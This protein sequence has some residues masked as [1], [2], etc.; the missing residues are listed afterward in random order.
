MSISSAQTANV[1]AG[2]SGVLAAASWAAGLHL[3]LQILA[4]A[5]A[6]WAAVAAGAYHWEKRK[7]IKAQR[8]RTEARKLIDH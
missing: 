7:L 5:A 8:E 6:V 1:A 3:F 2:G 4:T